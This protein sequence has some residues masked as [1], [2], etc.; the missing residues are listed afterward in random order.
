M[1][2]DGHVVLITGGASGIGLAIAKVFLANGNKVLVTGR[3]LAKL[4]QV[5]EQNPKL[6]IAQSDVTNEEDVTVLVTRM[7]QEFGGVDVLINNAGILDTFD[8]GKQNHPLER[9]LQEVDIN[10]MAPIRMVH[11]FLP[12][13]KRSKQAAIVNVSS[14]LAYVP[15]SQAPVYTATK[16]AIHAWTRAMRLHLEPHGTKVLELLPPLVATPMEQNANIKGN[17]LKLMPPEVLAAAFWKGFLR[18]EE[19]ITPG[20]AR[21]LRIMGRV[22]PAFIFKQLNKVAVPDQ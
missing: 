15:F 5:K 11:H 9:Q 17:T 2:K 16:S 7:Q 10:F 20:I 22:A 19:E 3:N 8:L 13:L 1:K 6:H 4:D 14:S 18:D 21:M 12:Q